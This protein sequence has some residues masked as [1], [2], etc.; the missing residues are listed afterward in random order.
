MMRVML[1]RSPVGVDVREVSLPR[2]ASQMRPLARFIHC[3]DDRV[4]A[5]EDSFG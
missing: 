1:L 4:I 5:V 3:A 2:R